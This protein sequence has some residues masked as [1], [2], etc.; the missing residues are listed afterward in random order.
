MYKI[1]LFFALLIVYHNNQAQNFKPLLVNDKNEFVYDA[2]LLA[3]NKVAILSYQN[4]DYFYNKSEKTN[5][6]NHKDQLQLVD[7]VFSKLSIVSKSGIIENDIS[8]YSTQD[9]IFIYEQI[10]VT[11]NEIVLWGS[12]LTSKTNTKSSV[13]LSFDLEI[14][15]I[16]V[17]SDTLNFG[18]SYYFNVLPNT[19]ILCSSLM[20]ALELDRYGNLIKVYKN[21]NIGFPFI[22]DI[23]QN[24][25]YPNPQSQTVF[26]YSTI[27][28][29]TFTVE[30][31]QNFLK[32]ELVVNSK[33]IVINSNKSNFYINTLFSTGCEVPQ[34]KSTILRYNMSDLSSEIFY[35]DPTS[36]C[37]N[38]RLGQFDIDIYDDD[39]IYFTNKAENCNFI[40]PEGF[41]TYCEVEYVTL[42]CLDQSGNLRWSKYMGGDALYIVNGVIATVDKGCMI[43][44]SRYKHWV[45]QQYETDTYFLSF[46]KNGNL[47][48]PTYINT[49][50]VELDNFRIRLYPNPAKDR[51]CIQMFG[52]IPK[53]L[54][55][56]VFNSK[57]QLVLSE[58]LNKKIVDIKKLAAG[59]YNYLVYNSSQIIKIGKIIKL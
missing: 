8:F 52:T 22:N 17:Y 37:L 6:E 23:N 15:N 19:N 20:G 28:D 3:I 2:A 33:E 50:E 16:N 51:I 29:S 12:V 31:N 38:D 27:T 5:Y 44:V 35:Q 47:I 34:F 4:S 18:R 46:D 39:Y 25:V 36:N 49:N 42:S 56:Y 32:N 59:N 9:S 7:S 14:Q 1:L 26:V 24:Y 53:L 55:I 54:Y 21:W 45:N 57:G 48:E 13:W 30:G 41:E 11:N 58:K 43:F 10:Y 40:P